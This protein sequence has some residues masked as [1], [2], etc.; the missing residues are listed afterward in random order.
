[1]DTEE[2]EGLMYFAEGDRLKSEDELR[3][4]II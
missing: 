2:Q 3:A 1:M 4:W